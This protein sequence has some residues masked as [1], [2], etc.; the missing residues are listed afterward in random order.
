[1]ILDLLSLV[2]T[3]NYNIHDY[4]P[5]KEEFYKLTKIKSRINEYNHSPHRN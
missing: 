1:M 4:I 2:R 3:N 5:D